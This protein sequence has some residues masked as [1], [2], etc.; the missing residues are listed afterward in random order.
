MQPCRPRIAGLA[1]AA[2]F[3]C[4]LALTTSTHA[5]ELVIA[6]KSAPQA[7]I[8]LAPNA[9]PWEQRAATDLQK[10]IRL[11]SGAEPA[12]AAVAPEAGAPTLYVGQAAL[13]IDPTLR[14]ALDRVAKP[15][16]A[17]RS[18]AIV[19]RRNKNRVLLAGSNDELTLFCR[20]VASKPVGLPLVSANRFWRSCTGEARP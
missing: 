3:A 10:Y 7:T 11:M 15:S 2:V 9:G 13:A 12:I 20:R 18:D 4:V 19:V 1:L 14:T 8:V 6:S 17:I 16:P 5:A